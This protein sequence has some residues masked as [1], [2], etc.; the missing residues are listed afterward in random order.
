MVLARWRHHHHHLVPKLF[1]D[2]IEHKIEEIEAKITENPLYGELFKYLGID[3]E[4]ND[5]LMAES[6]IEQVIIGENYVAGV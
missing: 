2:S 6:T 5:F 4:E 3:Y 1:R